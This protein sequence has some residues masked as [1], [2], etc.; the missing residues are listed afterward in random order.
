MLSNSGYYISCFGLNAHWVRLEIAKDSFFISQ[1]W[2][3][4]LIKSGYH[5]GL[6]VSV[7]VTLSGNQ[8]VGSC[9][10][11]H[12]MAFGTEM[13]ALTAEPGLG[14]KMDSALSDLWADS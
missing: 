14:D 5:Q 10:P 9:H 12:L 1:A 8:N 7:M 6:V 4:S 11:I 13:L 2:Q 3:K